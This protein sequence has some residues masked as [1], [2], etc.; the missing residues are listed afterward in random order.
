M[1][2]KLGL[3][4]LSHIPIRRRHVHT[5]NTQLHT[6]TR[7][8]THSCAG[9]PPPPNTHTDSDA[10]TRGQRTLETIRNKYTSGHPLRLRG[11]APPGSPSQE[12]APRDT[13][14][15]YSEIT[16]EGNV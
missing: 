1:K 8:H 3:Q 10:Y 2:K 13:G 11:S 4:C 5:H 12:R 6:D 7:S 15:L 16:G 14:V 9:I